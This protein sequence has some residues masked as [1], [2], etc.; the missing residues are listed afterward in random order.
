[1]REAQASFVN[2]SGTPYAGETGVS[3]M[4]G[5]ICLAALLGLGIGSAAAQPPAAPV[6]PAK[7]PAFEVVSIRANQSKPEKS[8]PP[9]G[10]TPDGYHMVDSPLLVPMLT[11][12]VPQSGAGFFSER[13]VRGLPDWFIRDRYDIDAKVAQADV[14]QW[15]KPASRSV[16]LP[17][18]LQAMFAD[19]FKMAV[20][21]EMNDASVFLL[22]VGKGGPKFKETNPGEEHPEGTKLPGGGVLVNSS[23]GLHLYG[24]SMQSLASLLSSI[25]E[26]AAGRPIQD[27][28]GLNGSYDITLKRPD[29][30]P[31]PPTS[32]GADGA[33]QDPGSA[34]VMS[35][36]DDL[37][38]KLA[39]S[40]APVEMLVIDH[41]EKPTAN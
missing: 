7:R 15:Q 30:I 16:M 2:F 22:K 28:T 25:G 34:I 6:A 36:V 19:R 38:L 26:N 35:L 23:N 14:A 39:P 37:G 13:Q 10:P 11:A 40:K 33:A 9:P 4:I 17:L 24:V 20:H 1:M 29:S 31:P 21:R 41:I 18:M 3:G 5:K 8:P 27:K 12:Y 32:G